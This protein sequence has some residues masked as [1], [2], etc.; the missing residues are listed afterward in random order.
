MRVYKITFIS[1]SVSDSCPIFCNVRKCR[2][3]WEG[4]NRVCHT[5]GLILSVAD[6]PNITY[7][8]QKLFYNLKLQTL[9][10]LG[11]KVFDDNWYWLIPG[12]NSF[13]INFQFIYFETC[14]KILIF[15]RL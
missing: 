9:A 5:M 15:F 6:N 1:E 2:L 3:N 4:A 13:Y 8:I 12:E 14:F 11:G 7:E 10:W